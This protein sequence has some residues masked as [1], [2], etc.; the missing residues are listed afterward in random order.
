MNYSRCLFLFLQRKKY[1]SYLLKIKLWLIFFTGEPKLN[2]VPLDFFYILLQ[3]LCIY[4]S[5]TLDFLIF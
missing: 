4:F 1:N 5:E 3:I 2:I